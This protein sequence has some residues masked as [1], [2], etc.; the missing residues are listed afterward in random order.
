MRYFAIQHALLKG[1]FPV[2]RVAVCLLAFV[3]AI[4]VV[5]IFS[6]FIGVRGATQ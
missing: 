1:K 5:I 4:N 3:L 6:I 2:A